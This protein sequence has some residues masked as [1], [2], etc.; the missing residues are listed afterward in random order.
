[1]LGG[2]VYG[3]EQTLHSGLHWIAT[4][5]MCSTATLFQAKVH[6][7]VSKQLLS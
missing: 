2:R 5:E 7:H 6:S 1:M 4:V 3:S